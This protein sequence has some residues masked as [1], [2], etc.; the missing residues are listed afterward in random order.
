MKRLRQCVDACTV[1]ANQSGQVKGSFCIRA[2]MITHLFTQ[3]LPLPLPPGGGDKGRCMWRDSG[4]TYDTQSSCL[5]SLSL[6]AR[7][8]AAVCLS[9]KATRTTD[10]SRTVTFA[11]IAAITDALMRVRATDVPS[12][13]SLHY[14]GAAGG[15]VTPFGFDIGGFA[16]ESATMMFADPCLAAARTRVLDYFTAVSARVPP[17][18]VVFQFDR[19]GDISAGDAALVEQLCVQMGFSRDFQHGKYEQAASYLSG[20][21]SEVLDVYPELGVFRDIVFYLKLVMVPTA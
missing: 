12:A 5:H 8:F 3:V 17:G 20:Q 9:L 18:H 16:D 7:H 6:I 11:A 13:L 2:S 10:A 14:A 21:R 19:S 15:P 4:M 1:L